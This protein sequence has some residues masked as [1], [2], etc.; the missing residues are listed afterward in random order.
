MVENRPPCRGA[1]CKVLGSSSRPWRSSLHFERDGQVPLALFIR[2]LRQIR[3]GI[4]G[5]RADDRTD[6]VIQGSRGVPPRGP[7][8]DGP[9]DPMWLRA[10][11][12]VSRWRDSS[13]WRTGIQRS[14]GVPPRG[15]GRDG[16]APF[17]EAASPSNP[18]NPVVTTK[19]PGRSNLVTSEEPGEPMA[20]QLGVA[21]WHS[22]EG[23]GASRPGD[24]SETARLLSLRR[25]GGALRWR[26]GGPAVPIRVAARPEGL[27]L[28]DAGSGA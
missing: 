3:L 19:R 25:I 10:R 4:Q 18:G 26:R 24:R 27:S 28:A 22:S 17:G 21:H 13:A 1:S 7:G 15:S 20:R 2:R 23:A 14:R 16:P 11:N 9:A 6:R 12:L 5:R 8:R